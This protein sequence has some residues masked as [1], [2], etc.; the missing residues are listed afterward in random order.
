MDTAELIQLKKR[1][2][3]TPEANAILDN[4]LSKWKTS[5]VDVTAAAQFD[6]I[7]VHHKERE[8]VLTGL[9]VTAL[10]A[11]PFTLA[12]AP[13]LLG[14]FL[15]VGFWIQFERMLRA[16]NRL[17]NLFRSASGKK[18]FPVWVTNIVLALV[19]VFVVFLFTSP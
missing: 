19:V 5:P 16:F 12:A 1:G 10:V 6:D 17:V 3:L 8:R 13:R 2:T 4:E 15:A 7:E 11:S 14:N 9:A 18:P